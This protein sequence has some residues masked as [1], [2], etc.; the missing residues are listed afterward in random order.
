MQLT[1]QQH[2]ILNQANQI[3][4]EYT[5][6]RHYRTAIPNP[7]SVKQLFRF[8]LST[9]EHEEFHVLC[10]DT[11]HR[12]ISNICMFKGTIDAAS[13]YP[14]EVAKHALEQNAT[15]I[16]VA[17]NHPSGSPEPSQADIQ[18]TRRL[19]SAMETIEVKFLDHIIV[20]DTLMSFAERGL[21]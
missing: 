15:A 19:Q 11:H 1:P 21:I 4:E 16:I 9:L 14:R 10:L 13:V 12:I 8:K 17:H 3:M 20:G 2:A 5:S 6:L 18:I 7:D